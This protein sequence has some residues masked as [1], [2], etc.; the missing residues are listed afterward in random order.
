MT[1][2]ELITERLINHLSQ[3]INRANSIYILTS[4][5]MKSGVDILSDSLKQAAERGADIKICTGDYLFI[6]QPEALSALKEIHTGDRGTIMAEQW[7]FFSSKGLYF[8]I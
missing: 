3:E 1:K 5:A 7:Y 4:F 6:T 2:I 8:P